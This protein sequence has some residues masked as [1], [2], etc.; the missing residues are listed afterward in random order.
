M[1]LDKP[2]NELTTEELIEGI[3]EKFA[4]LTRFCEVADINWYHLQHKILRRKDSAKKRKALKDI[5]R[6][7]K[8]LSPATTLAGEVS[9]ELRERMRLE[10]KEQYGT[11]TAFAEKHKLN[12]SM[13]YNILNNTNYQRKDGAAKIT[14]SIANILKLLK[15][16][17]VPQQA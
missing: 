4:T 2:F 3:R 7:A 16:K 14:D 6:K 12:V 13:V 1:I 11:V 10:I 17:D 5:Y 9:D 8:K 15:I